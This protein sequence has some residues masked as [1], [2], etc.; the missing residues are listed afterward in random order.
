MRNHSDVLWMQK[1]APFIE[2]GTFSVCSPFAFQRFVH[3]ID[4]CDNRCQERAP[5]DPKI[6]RMRNDVPGSGS[7]VDARH[8]SSPYGVRQQLRGSSPAVVESPERAG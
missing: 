6:Y 1:A 2:E 3:G 5:T 8:I 7:H 4:E